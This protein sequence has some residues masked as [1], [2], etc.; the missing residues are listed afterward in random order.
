M[1]LWKDKPRDKL[2]Y[3]MILLSLI[4]LPM[5]PTVLP[6]FCSN[7]KSFRT[8]SQSEKPQQVQYWIK[9]IAYAPVTNV[10]VRWKSLESL[11]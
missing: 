7:S 10:I 1:A 11:L 8:D 5:G 6:I 2:K 4:F 3:K 9:V